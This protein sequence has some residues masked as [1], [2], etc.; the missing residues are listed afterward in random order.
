M[1]KRDDER[2][3]SLEE[4]SAAALAG[5]LSDDDATFAV[6]AGDK[7]DLKARGF[8]Y[9][10]YVLRWD[11][12][13][14]QVEESRLLVPDVSRKTAVRLG[15]RYGQASVLYKAGG[16]ISEICTAPSDDHQ[17]GDTLAEHEIERDMP[18]NAE[19]VRSIFAV[20]C[21]S[22][23]TLELFERQLLNTRLGFTMSKIEIGEKQ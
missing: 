13:G 9:H 19:T 18:L 14:S 11:E 17:T 4:K 2:I 10:E 12:R 1:A 23:E 16:V 6:L 7:S 3:L 8:G 21:D 5:Y 22:P 15:E 20:R